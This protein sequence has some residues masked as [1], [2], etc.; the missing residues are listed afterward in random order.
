MT[1]HGQFKRQAHQIS[2]ISVHVGVGQRCRAID[3]ESPAIL[4]TMNTRNVPAGR[5]RKCHRMFKPR[6]LCTCDFPPVIFNPISS[7]VP[8]DCISKTRQFLMA[9][10][11]TAPG[12]S[13]ST[14][15]ARL[16]QT[17][18]PVHMSLLSATAAVNSPTVLADT[19][20]KLSGGGGDGDGGDGLGGDGEGGGGD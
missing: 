14:V 5:W 6:A 18:D 8:L 13:A 10:S 20:F 19:W 1:V 12:T 3:V 11:T 2:L 15:R 16:M 9:L 4:P 17:A 7:A